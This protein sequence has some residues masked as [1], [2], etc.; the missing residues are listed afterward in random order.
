MQDALEWAKEAG[1]K[2][3]DFFSL[4]QRIATKLISGTPL[5]QEDRKTRD[6]FHLGFGITPK[7]LPDAYVWFR[8]PFLR[9]I[10]RLLTG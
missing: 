10:G 6:M 8:N 5:S 4:N 1:Y 9:Y 2:I 3:F 7:I